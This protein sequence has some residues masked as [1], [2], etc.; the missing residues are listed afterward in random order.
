MCLF[1]KSY[2]IIVQI[3]KF[4]SQSAQFGQNFTSTTPTNYHLFATHVSVLLISV[5][6]RNAEFLKSNG[7][8]ILM[9]LQEVQKDDK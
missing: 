3:F 1:L 9:E 7:P 5:Y 2:S 6:V 4:A 8:L